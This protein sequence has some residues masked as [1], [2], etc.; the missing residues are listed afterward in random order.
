MLIWLARVW[1][2]LAHFTGRE[3]YYAINMVPYVFCDW[4]APSEK[5][6]REL[7][8]EPT[9][10]EDGARQTLAWYRQLGVGPSHWLSRMVMKLWQ[11]PER[12]SS[13]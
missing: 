1:T 13:L 2:A 11:V 10:F 7:D 3:P 6:R 9:P 4:N 12:D 8:L 5:A